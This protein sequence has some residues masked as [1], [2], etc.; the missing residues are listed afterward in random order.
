MPVRM[1]VVMY[2]NPSNG[3]VVQRRA[4]TRSLRSTSLPW[5]KWPHS[6]T[7]SNSWGR[8]SC[9]DQAHDRRSHHDDAIQLLAARFQ[10]AGQGRGDKAAEGE[11]QQA[12]RQLGMLRAQPVAHCLGIVHLAHMH[13]V[14]ASAGAHAPVVEAQGAVAGVTGGALQ[15]GDHLVEHGAA[16]DR[17]GMADQRQ[18]PG[19]GYRQI[20]GFD[21]AAGAVELQGG[22][23]DEQGRNSVTRLRVDSSWFRSG[24]CMSSPANGAWARHQSFRP[25]AALYGAAFGGRLGSLT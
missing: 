18:A 9:A 15:G 23:A 10:T 21:R 22:F 7:F 6:A 4:L 19:V 16:L 1:R 24:R 13:V 17:V 3:A 2:A 12:Q 8:A 5:K 25:F 20:E 14:G 11:T